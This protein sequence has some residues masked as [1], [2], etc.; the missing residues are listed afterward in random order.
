MFIHLL[1]CRRHLVGD[2][3]LQLVVFRDDG[4]GALGEVVHVLVR[5]AAAAPLGAASA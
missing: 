1:V 4:G 2:L 3:P 5:E